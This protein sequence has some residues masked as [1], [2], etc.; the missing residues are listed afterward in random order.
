MNY[1]VVK[2]F[3][4]I[5]VLGEYGGHKL[6]HVFLMYARFE[7]FDGWNM[8][9]SVRILECHKGVVCAVCIGGVV[10]GGVC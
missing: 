6:V 2:S 5:W 10:F 1:W 8:R 3:C 9:N 4:Y 7:V